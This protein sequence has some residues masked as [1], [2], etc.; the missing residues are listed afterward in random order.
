MPTENRSSN[1]EMVSNLLPCP[2]CGDKPQITKHHREDIYSF[3]HRCQV[4]GP[5]SWGFREDQQTH[6]EKWN[7]RVKPAPQPHPEPIAWMVGTAFWWTKEE[8]ERDA[9]DTGL[10]I[11][12]L[13]PM[14]GS[15]EIDQLQLEIAKLQLDLTMH[16]AADIQDECIRAEN[17][18][19]RARLD[20]WDAALDCMTTTATS[21]KSELAKR[22]A[23]LQRMKTL[24]RTDDPFDLYDAVCNAL[25]GK[26]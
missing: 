12:G 1:T 5:I 24:F 6:V 16:D 21:Y 8:A 26:S 22:D 15:A 18:E 17:S 7:A 13:G 19:L 25:V 23:L 20:E 10:P 4:L 11:V 14:A 2:F 9:A 3:M